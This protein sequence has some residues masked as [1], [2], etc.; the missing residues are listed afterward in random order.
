M[1]FQMVLPTIQIFYSNLPCLFS[2][3]RKMNR[4]HYVEKSDEKQWDYDRCHIYLTSLSMSQSK[5]L[6]SK[7][8][9]RDMLMTVSVLRNMPECVGLF[10]CVENDYIICR[11]KVLNDLTS[12]ISL[13]PS[14]PGGVVRTKVPQEEK[15]IAK[16]SNMSIQSK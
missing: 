13:L 9:Y 2:T 16:L 12:P 3:D 1:K 6:P 8:E 11:Y 10:L 5:H 15:G 14:P 7:G 4:L